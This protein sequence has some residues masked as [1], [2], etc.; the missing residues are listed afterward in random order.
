MSGTKEQERLM[1]ELDKV[2]ARNYTTLT[3]RAAILLEIFDQAGQDKL[4]RAA[5]Y[6]HW[7]A[8]D[9]L[10]ATA[11][12]PVE[13][14]ITDEEF[15]R[16]VTKAWASRLNASLAS[17]M[18]E[19]QP[20]REVVVPRVMELVERSPHRVVALALILSTDFTPYVQVPPT[21]DSFVTPSPDSRPRVEALRVSHAIQRIARLERARFYPTAAHALH[22]TMQV[23]EAGDLT[24]FERAS[25]LIDVVR[26]WGSRI[27]MFE[28]EQALT[29]GLGL[30]HR[31]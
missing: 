24:P 12:D 21:D 26:C 7:L 25:L 3:G 18:L 16:E 8:N 13:G 28:V 19:Q 29:H 30:G 20:L 22:A 2:L 27:A 23:I 1:A 4:L 31:H 9:H 14:G 10:V 17:I 11:G 15:A 6:E 5:L